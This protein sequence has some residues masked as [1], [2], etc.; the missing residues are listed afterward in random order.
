MI[1]EPRNI[2]WVREWAVDGAVAFRIGR[3]GDELVAEWP[4]V[5]AMRASESGRCH[6]FE[7]YADL[8]DD[9]LVKFRDG[10][11]AAFLRHLQGELALHASAVS[12]RDFV[13]TFL[14]P[15]GAGKSTT[16]A[17]LCQRTGFAML[18]DD[19][20]FV[21]ETPRGLLAIPTESAH[22]LLPDAAERV[23]G[24]PAASKI[25]CKPRRCAREPA[26]LGVFVVLAWSGDAGA[27]TLRRV[28]G[29][30]AFRNLA[31]SQL[32]FAIDDRAKAATDLALLSRVSESA[33]MFELRRPASLSSLP[34]IHTLLD[35]LVCSL[36]RGGD[37]P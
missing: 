17:A 28:S 19:V 29:A 25:S 2:R 31:Q 26:R 16:A 21:E 8:P 14:G 23:A 1:A 27:P 9:R 36:D 22:W 15:S 24:V 13:I 35:E 33:P 3:E 20:L 5:C 11:A 4:G 37:A 34:S 30:E 10:L 6:R 32:R 12:A 18:A 7:T